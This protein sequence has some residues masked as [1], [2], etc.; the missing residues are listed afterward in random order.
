MLSYQERFSSPHFRSVNLSSLYNRNIAD[1]TP[2]DCS[3]KA[4]EKLRLFRDQGSIFMGIPFSVDP[5]KI[6]LLKNQEEHL[7]FDVPFSSRFI[8]ILHAA[9]FKADEARQDGILSPMR[10]SPRLGEVVAEY[11]LSYSDGT[12]YPVP[13]RRRFSIGELDTHSFGEYCFEAAPHWKPHAIRT[14]TEEIVRGRQ[15]LYSWG[16]SQYRSR[17][18]NHIGP[19]FYWL[20][21]LENPYPDKEMTRITFGPKDG[22]VFIFGIAF[23]NLSTNPLR[24][25]ER[26][27]IVVRLP[28]GEELGVNG[29]YDKVD[30]DLGAVISVTPVL[31]YGN[32]EWES[33]YNN[34][35]ATASKNSI[36]IEY[37]ANPEAILYMGQDYSCQF[38]LSGIKKIY[39]EQIKQ[40]EN[41]KNKSYDIS[42]L[43][44]QT[45]NVKITVVDKDN[46]EPVAVKLH[47]HGRA[48]EYLAL[49]N[50][51]RIPNPFWFEDYGV[52]FV[53]GNH[54][55]TYINGRAEA[56]LPLGDVYIE[57]SKG[58]E[59]TPVRRRYVVNS[60]T[61]EIRI[62][63]EHV[64]PWRQ[65]GW[66]TADTHVHFL[67]PQSALLEGE[68]EGIN[69]VNLLATQLGEFLTNT[70]D[71][72]GK[73]T[74]GSKENGGRGEYLIRV[75][76]ENR[77]HVLGHISLLGYEGQMILPLVAGGPDESPL[78]DPVDATLSEW[79]LRC[80]RQGGISI[81]PHFPEPRGEGA[82]AI[83]LKRIDGIEM[84]SWE[85]LYKGISTYSLSDW[86]RFLNCGYQVPAVG[87]TDKMS[88]GMAVGTVRTYARVR[89]NAFTY[90]SW[91]QAVRGG[92]TFVT[93]G[94]LLDFQVNGKR[95][96][97]KLNLP[98]TGGTL[99]IDW[100][101]ATV[102]V[103][104]T[105]V[106]LIFNGETKDTKAV[107]LGTIQCK[108]VF[109]LKV[110]ESGWI[111]LRVRGRYPDK[112]E[113]ITAHSSSIMVN[114]ERKPCFNHLDAISILEQIEGATAY[115][116]TIG[117][118]AEER[119]YKRM[120]LTLTAA[121]RSL[122]NRMHQNG[123]YHHH[124]IV[125]E[126]H[127]K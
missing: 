13:I 50:R 71:F 5:N 33:S 78:G 3:E 42:I 57:V 54:F 117:I 28:E 74:I 89:Q 7:H 38:R 2:T 27:K 103:P 91:K 26:K 110:R 4:L 66:V 83:I 94:P 72:D 35:Q 9:D 75:G 70:G 81:L 125:D 48:G 79:A 39:P 41:V 119:T 126:H 118:K 47:I 101:V 45:R 8:V 77:Q 20:F 58:F 100:E 84:T 113:V 107:D 76:T 53:H 56:K 37:T 90:D 104:I 116:K 46:D 52:E 68:A 17:S 96:G 10:G 115:I 44:A 25:E 62:E 87:G 122:H 98:A 18:E 61:D 14:S 121:H 1:L 51:H 106:E 6:L 36:I 85:F 43:P 31:D 112:P 120:L 73:T 111:A 108:G 19:P 49:K 30:I 22:I 40:S 123:M 21:A 15:P 63:L 93:Y 69:V 32:E 102:T 60:R 88:A 99:D 95:M 67:S 105:K 11:I 64:L 109:S 34:K 65:K 127:Q 97:S 114:V 12:S 24:W 124:T 92:E 23:C 29:D 80:R 82:A 16:I 55:C 86:Y 59:I